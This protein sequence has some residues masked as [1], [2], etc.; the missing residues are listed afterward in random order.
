MDYTDKTVHGEDGAKGSLR[1]VYGDLT[2]GLHGEGKDG[3]FH[4]LFSYAA[5]G[6]VSCVKDGT[7]WMYRAP[8]PCFWRALTDNDRGNKFA[9]RSGTWLSADLFLNCVGIELCVDGNEIPLPCAPENNRYSEKE[10]ADRIRISYTYE[11][12]TQPSTRVG[13]TYEVDGG[14]VIDVEVHY[15]GK[16]GLPELPVFGMRFIMPTCADKFVYEGLSG[17][18][19]PDRMAGGIPGVYEVK[20]LPV[21]PYLVPQDCGMHMNSKWVEIHRSSVL[22]NSRKEERNACLRFEA[23]GEGFAFSA[24]PYTAQE[25]E[26]ATHMDE[27]PPQRRTV[28]CIC[29][30]VR[31]VGGIDSWFSDVEPAYHIDA[32]KDI[33]YSFRI[34]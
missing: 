24:L 3:E 32:G 11:T 33:V 9:L 1:V 34:R 16:E 29:G 31:G 6:L 26:N 2:L 7:E 23:V 4:Y 30:A 5:G 19:Y 20:G 13:V 27:L 21:T 14:G 10:T 12:I 15:F 17:E 22:D 25:L 28:L 8:R 18:T